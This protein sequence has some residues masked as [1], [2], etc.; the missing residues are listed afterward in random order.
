MMPTMNEPLAPEWMIDL[1]RR[2][3]EDSEAMAELLNDEHV[4]RHVIALHR[5]LRQIEENT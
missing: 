4:E 3:R 1:A 2:A 5:R